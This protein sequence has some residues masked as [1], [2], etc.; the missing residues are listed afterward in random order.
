MTHKQIITDLYKLIS[1]ELNN[2]LP[3]QHTSGKRFW[4]RIRKY[5][6]TGQFIDIRINTALFQRHFS[7][8]DPDFF[9]QLHSTICHEIAHI[10]HWNH[11]DSHSLLTAIYKDKTQQVVLDYINQI[12]HTQPTIQTAAQ[13]TNI[14]TLAD[15]V[16]DTKKARRILRKHNINKPSTGWNWS[17]TVPSEILELIKGI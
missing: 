5:T 13:S 8:T 14:I 6:S 3:L 16:S 7:T 12:T 2:P 15:L 9:L 1:T 4:G 11:T 17:D 10:Q